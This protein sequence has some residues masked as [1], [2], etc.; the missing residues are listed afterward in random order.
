MAFDI[1]FDPRRYPG[2]YA[3][4]DF[5]DGRPAVMLRGSD[6]PIVLS[7]K[8]GRYGLYI[9]PS[10]EFPFEVLASGDVRG[11]GKKGIECT[12]RT[13]AIVTNGHITIEPRQ[14]RGIY[15]ITNA[16]IGESPR[17]VI[18]PIDMEN[19]DPDGGYILE[20][21]PGNAFRFN[22]DSSGQPRPSAKYT[23]CAAF[24]GRSMLLNTCAITVEP[25]SYAR[26]WWIT[27][28]KPRPVIGRDE[29]ILIPGL[30]MSGIDVGYILEL[31]VGAFARFGVTPDG[32]PFPDR[33][34]IH[35]GG[36]DWAFRLSRK[37]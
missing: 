28:A 7:L 29:A 21:A 18:L 4:R 35:Y 17:Q 9:N 2:L 31:G 14:Y 25:E 37:P 16:G 20:I 12:G 36:V 8:P 32:T 11:D 27:G 10:A 6:G 5:P 33:V 24:H 13:V 26:G 15:G 34:T 30:P 3:C 23:A 19:P 1:T 22:V